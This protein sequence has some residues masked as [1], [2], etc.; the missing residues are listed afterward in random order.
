[1][2]TQ[3]HLLSVRLSACATSE[4]LFARMCLLMRLQMSELRITVS[5]YH[6]PVGFLARMDPRMNRQCV[7]VNERFSTGRALVGLLFRVSL[8]MLEHES[9]VDKDLVT[10]GAWNHLPSVNPSMHSQASDR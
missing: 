8:C 7:L 4:W 3:I 9:F 2:K 10:R 1:M 5:A 6:A